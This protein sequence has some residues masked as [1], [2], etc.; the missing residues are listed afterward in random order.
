MSHRFFGVVTGKAREKVGFLMKCQWKREITVGKKYG[1]ALL[2]RK[3]TRGCTFIGIRAHNIGLSWRGLKRSE[4]F[5]DM[6]CGGDDD[7]E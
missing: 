5:P 7:E 1:I 2:V 4:R 3:L 6:T